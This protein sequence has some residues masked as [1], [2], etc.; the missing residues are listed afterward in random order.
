MTD[1]NELTTVEPHRLYVLYH[2]SDDDARLAIATEL[3]VRDDV[4]PDEVAV[5][6]DGPIYRGDILYDSYNRDTIDTPFTMVAIPEDC[7]YAALPEHQEWDDRFEDLLDYHL[8]L[9]TPRDVAQMLDGE[10]SYT[11]GG[12][13]GKN[14]VRLAALEGIQNSIEE[15]SIHQGHGPTRYGKAVRN[16]V[17]DLPEWLADLV[18]ESQENIWEGGMPFTDEDAARLVELL[19]IREDVLDQ[20]IDEDATELV[21]EYDLEYD[22]FREDY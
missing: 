6:S 19:F 5:D 3:S 12:R 17:T 8:G 22:R 16:R 7:I 18:I 2:E 9:I 10:P 11:T 1:N 20:N 14:A 4:E 21:R 13:E 15:F